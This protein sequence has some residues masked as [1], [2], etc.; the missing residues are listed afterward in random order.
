MLINL[1]NPKRK[2]A[3]VALKRQRKPLFLY[4]LTFDQ[5]IQFNEIVLFHQKISK[6][7]ENTNIKRKTSN[8]KTS[9][10]IDNSIEQ[11]YNIHQFLIYVY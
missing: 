4:Q 6:E 11:D 8:N 2:L 1:T 5:I 9:L 3:L 10:T 7:R